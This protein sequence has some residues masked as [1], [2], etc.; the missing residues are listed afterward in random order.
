MF[1]YTADEMIGQSILRLIP[2]ELHYEEEQILRTLR[3]G[4]RVDHYETT[5]RKKNGDPIE[6]SVTISPIRDEN[7]G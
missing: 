5:R 7:G 1:G 6:V 3:A 4:D 2:E